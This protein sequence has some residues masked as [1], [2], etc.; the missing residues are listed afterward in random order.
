M[1]L[2]QRGG[3]TL[4]GEQRGGDPDAGD[5]HRHH[6]GG[7]ARAGPAEPAAQ[8]PMKPEPVSE[9]AP[10]SSNKACRSG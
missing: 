5:G 7:T 9:G 3:G 4:A 2:H 10:P 8:V 1:L 6:A